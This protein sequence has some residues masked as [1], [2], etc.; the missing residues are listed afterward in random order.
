MYY[1]VHNM[2]AV[3]L[4]DLNSHITLK[5]TVL[6]NYTYC[7]VCSDYVDST[8]FWHKAH[9][10]GMQAILQKKASME[11]LYT[12]MNKGWIIFN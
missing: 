8:L 11:K 6:Q 5:D 2:I 3:L 9:L 10:Y 7:T 12:W 1:T 4:P